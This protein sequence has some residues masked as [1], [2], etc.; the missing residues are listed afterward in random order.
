M[1]APGLE[2][3]GFQ[4]FKGSRFQG[5]RVS[6]FQGLRVS[7]LETSGVLKLASMAQ[8]LHKVP[9][10]GFQSYTQRPC[11]KLKRENYEGKKRL[12][13]TFFNTKIYKFNKLRA[14]PY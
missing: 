13:K 3:S 1:R 10:P 11:P 6:R 8:S 5:L 12:R 2:G 14:W 7:G 9:S 4:G